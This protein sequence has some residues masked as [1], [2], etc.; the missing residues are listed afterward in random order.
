M[1]IVPKLHIL[2]ERVIGK[3]VNFEIDP[4]RFD[5]MKENVS[6]ILFKF[7]NKIRDWINM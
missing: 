7:P 1:D 5:I 4:K 6:F 2:L 3:L